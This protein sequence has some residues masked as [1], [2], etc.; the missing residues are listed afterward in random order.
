MKLSSLAVVL[1]LL[2][3]MTVAPV[4]AGRVEVKG[5]QNLSS[6]QSVRDAI[7]SAVNIACDS[8]QDVI[9][10]FTNDGF[11]VVAPNKYQD[12]IKE[13][14]EAG[15][16]GAIVGCVAGAT[17]AVITVYFSAGT[18]SSLAPLDVS[19]GT[20]TGIIYA[21]DAKSQEISARRK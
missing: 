12:D 15:F 19:A 1:L 21:L 14:I 17:V 6:N 13:L 4:M 7:Q 8:N 2:C 10:T 9:V 20:I 5:M 11:V 16:R 3:S 18:L